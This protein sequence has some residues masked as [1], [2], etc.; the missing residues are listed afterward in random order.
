MDPASIAVVS[1]AASCLGVAVVSTIP[2]AARAVGSLVMSRWSAGLLAAVVLLAVTARP[3]PAEG[4][5]PPP[6]VRLREPAPAAPEGRS[7]VVYT[8]V[9]GDSLW[10]IAS[11][12]L[13]EGSSTQPTTAQI[14]EFWPQIYDANRELIGTDP[15]L[16]LVG[17]ELHM[18]E[19]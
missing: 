8:V 3:R 15:N 6:A 13:A 19:E 7:Q 9:R 18:P 14:A 17:Q 4:V 5:E 1:I 10:R 11:H 12:F 2:D 16:I